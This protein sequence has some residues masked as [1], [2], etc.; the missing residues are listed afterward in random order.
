MGLITSN[1]HVNPYVVSLT[2]TFLTLRP[3]S[4]MQHGVKLS[5]KSG[6]VLKATRCLLWWLL[7]ALQSIHLTSWNQMKNMIWAS[8]SGPNK[9][10]EG[11]RYWSGATARR[12]VAVERQMSGLCGGRGYRFKRAPAVFAVWKWQRATSPVEASNPPA[13]EP[14]PGKVKRQRIRGVSYLRVVILWRH[15]FFLLL[16]DF[17]YPNC[18]PLERRPFP[19]INNWHFITAPLVV[20]GLR[21]DVSPAFFVFFLSVR[22]DVLIAEQIRAQSKG[23]LVGESARGHIILLE[24]G[25]VLS[26]RH[27]STSYL[28]SSCLSVLSGLNIH[29]G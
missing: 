20:A 1:M 28:A 22:W 17:H 13:V 8:G 12:A 21:F 19:S 7:Q 15:G 27:P 18:L 4:D 23:F 14:F 26:S 24:C 5:N 6:K 10:S 2:H 9:A 16:L 29:T 25:Q 3:H 11:G